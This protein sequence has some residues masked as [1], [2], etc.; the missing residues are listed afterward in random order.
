[1]R[2]SDWSSDVFSSDLGTWTQHR[3]KVA[4][5]EIATCGTVACMSRNVSAARVATL[6]GDFDRSPAYTGLADALRL[7]I[8]EG[9]TPPDTR[10]PRE[11]DLTNALRATR[12]HTRRAPGRETGGQAGKDA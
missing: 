8:S 6:V 11:R 12:T 5:C 7:L 3:R 4:F 2:I 1:M 9:R 10:M